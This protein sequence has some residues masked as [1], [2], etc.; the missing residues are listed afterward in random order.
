MGTLGLPELAVIA[1]LTPAL[2]WPK[3]PEIK[4]AIRQYRR[5]QNLPK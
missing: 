3:F 5:Q 2:L 1:I 4:R